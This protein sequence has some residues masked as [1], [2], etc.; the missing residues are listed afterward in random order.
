MNNA[1]DYIVVLNA[2]VFVVVLWKYYK[3]HGVDIYTFLLFVWTSSVLT[4]VV[5]FFIN[6]FRDYS[7]ITFLPLAVLSILLF[8]SF[9][10]IAKFRTAMVER[11]YLNNNGILIVIGYILVF[12]SIIPFVENFGIVCSLYSSGG[13]GNQFAEAYIMT[14]EGNLGDFMDTNM[15]WIGKKFNVVNSWTRDFIPILFFY[16][17]SFIPRR[18]HRV[19]KVGLLLA[20]LNPLLISLISGGRVG[21]VTQ[22]IYFLFLFILFR[23]FLPNR[24]IKL[25]FRFGVIGG[26]VFL[27]ILALVTIGRFENLLGDVSL[28]EFVFWYSG[29]G[30]LNFSSEMWHIKETMGGDNTLAFF[31][32]LMGLD[33]FVDVSARRSYWDYNRTGVTSYIFQTFIGDFWADFRYWTIPILILVVLTLIRLTKVKKDVPLYRIVIL[34]IWAKICLLGFTFYIYKTVESTKVLL[35]TLLMYSMLVLIHNYPRNANQKAMIKQKV[36]HY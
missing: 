14:N 3:R 36:C 35:T 17:I 4:S 26:G 13:V 29:E 2:C 28:L 32:D 22:L 15:S 27:L 7:S 5:F 6:T 25:L 18:K 19:L 12:V 33:T 34:S 30:V 24:I 20:S 31:K 16:F 21:I 8:I 10:P 23:N 9:K 1:A 11:V